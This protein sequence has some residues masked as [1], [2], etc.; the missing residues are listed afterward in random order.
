MTVVKLRVLGVCF[1]ASRDLARALMGIDRCC[2]E[3]SR[4]MAVPIMTPATRSRLG[5]RNRKQI[6]MSGARDAD[7]AILP[8]PACVGGLNLRSRQQRQ[9]RTHGDETQAVAPPKSR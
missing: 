3:I 9:G 8:R 1:T 2:E 6:N 7:L 4:R 5:R